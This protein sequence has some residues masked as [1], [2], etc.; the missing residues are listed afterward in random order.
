MSGRGAHAAD[1]EPAVRRFTRAEDA[2][3]AADS[4]STGSGSAGSALAAL[5]ARRSHSKVT[6]E[7]PSHAEL[8]RLIEAMS[9][10]A[11]H[12][13]LRPWRIIE[14]RGKARRKLGRG[15]AKASGGDRGKYIAKAERAPLIL[16][17]VVCPRPSRK[18]PLW[19]QEAVASGVAHL[20][21]LLLHEAGW[22]SIWKTGSEARSKAVRK[23]LGVEK[24]EYLLGW[25]YVGGIPQRDRR[26]KPRKP[27]DV[28][29]HLT[30]L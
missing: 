23:A 18:V 27:L 7:A 19:E 10:V 4:G 1:L 21:G 15:L 24:P 8:V 3:G 29:R 25:L 30:V 13:R 17:V 5:Q 20:L 28:D 16:V 2:S 11:D 12:S 9:S 6:D 14:L 26:P 22:G